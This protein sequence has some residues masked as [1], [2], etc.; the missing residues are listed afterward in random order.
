MKTLSIIAA[1]SLVCFSA[2]AQATPPDK[3]PLC[4][5]DRTST[6]LEKTLE[7]LLKQSDYKSASIALEKEFTACMPEKRLERE[8]L[9]IFLAMSYL[10]LGEKEKCKK[11]AGTLAK[12]EQLMADKS[13]SKED[14]ESVGELLSMSQTVTQACP[15]K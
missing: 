14:W 12:P 2:Y 8:T 7:P 1:L 4:E 15:P 6:F 13:I 10:E 5:K 9:A 11:I 3:L